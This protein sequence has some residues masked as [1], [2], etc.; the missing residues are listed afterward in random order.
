MQHQSS[1]TDNSNK[2]IDVNESVSESIISIGP[3]EDIDTETKKNVRKRKTTSVDASEPKLIDKKSDE[4][5]GTTKRQRKSK[6][7]SG[8]KADQ[9]K[10]VEIKPKRSRATKPKANPIHKELA[11]SLPL[12]DNDV[13]GKCYTK[14]NS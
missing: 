1:D 10:I 9:T 14:N 3:N 8:S 7:D 4:K 6:C 12:N 11:S 2:C 5:V 13:T